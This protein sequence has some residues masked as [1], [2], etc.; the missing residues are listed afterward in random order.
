MP[1]ICTLG[2]SVQTKVSATE[3]LVHAIVSLDTKVLLANVL[4][5]QTIAM[6]V[7]LA[8]QRS[9]W[10]PKLVAHILLHGTQ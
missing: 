6:I 9:C 2:P 4:S 8:G 3:L 5:A 7:V 10:L 1:T